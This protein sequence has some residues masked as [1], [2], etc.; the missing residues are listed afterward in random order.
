MAKLP[1]LNFAK[2]Q[3]Q[4]AVNSHKD[5]V[6]A[7]HVAVNKVNGDVATIASA[8]EKHLSHV[9]NQFQKHELGN[10]KHK[11]DLDVS[12]MKMSNQIATLATLVDIQ[13]KDTEKG[14]QKH[15]ERFVTFDTFTTGLENVMTIITDMQAEIE[16]LRNEFKQDNAKEFNSIRERHRVFAAELAKFPDLV[17]AANAEAQCKIDLHAIDSKSLLAELRAHKNDVFVMKKH[18]EDLYTKLGRLTKGNA[19]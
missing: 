18:I 16:M 9:S 13:R 1:K 4:D 8:L 6:L 19:P 7:S 5:A 15:I 3:L 17:S 14:L 10:Q 11:A 12:L 2:I